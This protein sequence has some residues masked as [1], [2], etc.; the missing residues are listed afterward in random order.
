MWDTAVEDAVKEAQE[1]MGVTFVY[2]V[3]KQ[4]FRDATQPMIEAY[5]EQYPG[6]KTLLDTVEAARGEE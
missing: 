3:D 1:T 5:E 6:V 2:D 4:A